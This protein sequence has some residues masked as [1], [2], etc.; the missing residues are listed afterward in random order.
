[1]K[2]HIANVDRKTRAHVCGTN[3]GLAGTE[4]SAF[5]TVGFP[6]NGTAGAE[7]DGT[8]HTSEFEERELYTLTDNIADLRTPAR[9]AVSGEALTITRT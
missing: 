3:L 6:R 2:N 5:L 8:A 7:N 4:R 9:V 1:M